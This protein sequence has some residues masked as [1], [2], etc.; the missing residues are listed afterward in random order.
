VACAAGGAAGLTVTTL[1]GC[2]QPAV[3]TAKA[4]KATRA[5]IYERYV[6][7]LLSAS[8]GD[9]ATC[10]L[11]TGYYSLDMTGKPEAAAPLL[12]FWPDYGPGPLWDAHGKA[13]EPQSLGLDADLANRLLAFNAAYEEERVPVDG[14]GDAEYLAEGTGLL[15]T[16]RAALNGRFRVIVTEPWWGEEPQAPNG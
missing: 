1:L 2:V 16:V 4:K 5:S 6:R 8:P 11:E 3:M 10:L 9:Q 7:R 15:A 14:P 12:E 13:L